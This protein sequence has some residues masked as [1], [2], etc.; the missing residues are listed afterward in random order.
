LVAIEA[1]AD[2]QQR[3]SIIPGRLADTFA[4][5]VPIKVLPLPVPVP[6]FDIRAFWHE[7]YH[8]DPP[9]RWLRGAFIKLF[10]GKDPKSGRRSRSK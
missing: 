9:N 10:Q 5:H 3:A 7:R 2:I 6:D 4:P 1:K 8:H